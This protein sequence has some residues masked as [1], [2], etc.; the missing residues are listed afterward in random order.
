MYSAAAAAA[1]AAASATAPAAVAAAVAAA[2]VAA[3]ADLG[4]ATSREDQRS[5]SSV[6]WCA[7]DVSKLYCQILLFMT[8]AGITSITNVVSW[9]APIPVMWC[10]D[11]LGRESWDWDGQESAVWQD[12]SSREAGVFQSR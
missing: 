12:P 3:S 8:R 2:A 7:F 5:V 1:A 11:N 6:Y 9:V 10:L 4:P